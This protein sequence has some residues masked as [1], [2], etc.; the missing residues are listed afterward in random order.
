MFTK[1]GSCFYGGPSEVGTQAPPRAARAVAA[2]VP[3]AL[4]VRFL[5]E[6]EARF[7]LVFMRDCESTAHATAHITDRV[8]R[9]P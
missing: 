7:L 1:L 2:C 8:Q 3:G 4:R 5:R 6:T 9:V